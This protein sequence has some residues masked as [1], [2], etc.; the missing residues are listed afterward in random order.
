MAF[1]SFALTKNEFLSGI[2]TVTRRDWAER[3]FRQWCKWW[4][5]GRVIHDAWDKAP[6]AGG[7]KIG[8]FIM[9]R[10]PY[11]ERLADMP[12]SDLVAEGNMV[13]SLEEYFNLINKKPEDIVT[14]IR[15]KK[16]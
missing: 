10:R 6:F 15:F 2:K 5:C 3:R 9:T 14:V 1:I 11:L 16:L 7:H 4:D 12:V 13:S 8:S